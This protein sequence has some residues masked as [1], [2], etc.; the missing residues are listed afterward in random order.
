MPGTGARVSGRSRFGALGCLVVVLLGTVVLPGVLPTSAANAAAPPGKVFGLVPAQAALGGAHPAAPL[1]TPGK[2]TYHNGPVM[3]T[4]TTYAIYWIPAGYSVSANY[5][6]VINGF[7]HNVSAASGSATNVYASD[8]QYYDGTGYVAYSSTFAGAVVDTTAFPVSG[9]AVPSGLLACLTDAQLQT[10]ITAVMAAH[11][12]TAGSTK[13]FFL[14]TPKNVTSCIGAD[15]AYVAFCAYHSWIGSGASA[16]IYAN[17]PYAGGAGSCDRA[18]R[19]NGDDADATINVLSHEHN[20]MITDPQGTGWLDATGQENGDECAWDFGTVLGGASGS[21]YNQVIN[22]AHYYLQ[23]E[24]DNS[25]GTCVLMQPGTAT[26]FSVSAPASSTSGQVVSVKVTARPYPNK[27]AAGYTGTVYFTSSDAAADLPDDYTFLAADKGVHTFKVKLMAAGSQ[28]VSVTDAA[29]SSVTGT[30]AADVVAAGTTTHFSVVGSSSSV[31]GD[32]VTVT[33]S[34]LNSFN[35]V[36]AG[37]AGTVA[38]TSSDAAATLPINATLTNGV[39]T[40][41]V[42]L[43]TQGSKTVVATDAAAATIKGSATV[44]VA[45]YASASLKAEIPA[46]STVGQEVSVKV[47]AID[48]GG[49]VDHDYAGV[50]H[51]TSTDVAAVLPATYTFLATEKGV[52]IFKATLMT[53]GSKTVTATDANG[54]TGTSAADVVAAGSVTHFGVTGPDTI[55]ADVAATVVVS[56]L[57]AFNEPVVGYTGIAHFT[58]SDA[59]TTKVPTLPA[60]YTFVGGDA[61]VHSFATI[62]LETVGKKTI[63]VNDTVTTTIKGVLAITV[64]AG[65]ATTLS[66]DAPAAGIAGKQLSGVKVTALDPGGNTATGYTGTVHFTSLTDGSAHL[67][68]NYTFTAADKGKHLFALGGRLMTAGNE[69]VTATDTVTGTITDTSATVK[70]DAGTVTHFSVTGPAT[71]VVNAA[72]TLVVTALNAYDATVVGY[73]GTAHFTS[74]D[75]NTFKAAVLPA[76]YP[77][78]GGDNGTHTFTNLT[79]LE[80]VGKQTITATDAAKSTVKGRTRIAVTIGAAATLK[81]TVP[82]YAVHGTATTFKVTAL[83]VGGNTATGY[84]GTVAVTSSDGA[85]TLP[86]N[87]VYVG[88]DNGKHTFAITLN[89]A[90][91]KTVTATDTVTGTI[92]GVSTAIKV[93]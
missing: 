73:T 75:A 38:I 31:A 19:P 17:Q 23:Q 2:L 35:A 41:V 7:F 39:G 74:T 81:V 80:T 22:G 36:V 43:N 58:T 20:E 76:D 63:A 8:T 16:T 18:Q 28:T 57:N 10:E 29:D 53:A 14:F 65:A 93:H 77:F 13:A 60:D 4:N 40:F 78:I 3:R 82:N 84:T 61:G 5:Q 52:H 69:T 47:T 55:V 91:N 27:V 30:S 9:C 25:S 85:A 48:A 6:T 56:A 83:D 37:Y 21:Y 15:C 62:K 12:W 79:T 87:H 70:I 33:V 92:T 26:Q 34:A 11:G 64:T 46:A 67:P 66:V 49:N 68:A 50:V 45:G 71:K 54:L 1:A 32:G 44:T 88:G 86:A 72:A 90:G 59:N 51:F 24:F 42:T 89:T